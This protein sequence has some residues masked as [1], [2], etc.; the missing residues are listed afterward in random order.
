MSLDGDYDEDNIFARI[1]RDEIPSIRV[2]ED[3]KI[4]ALM[5]VFPQARGHALVIHRISRARTLLDAEPEALMDLIVAVQ[6]VTLAIREALQPDGITVTQ[7]NG[8]PA[9]QTIFHLHFHIIPRWDGVPLGFHG[10][11]QADLGD[12]AKLAGLIIAKLPPA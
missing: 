12:L 10:G 2:F 8:A 9:G 5:D 3:D 11:G 6:R 7:F 1:L 4:V